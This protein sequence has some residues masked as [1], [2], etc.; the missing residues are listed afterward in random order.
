MGVKWHEHSLKY[1]EMRVRYRLISTTLD[2]CDPRF[3]H[4]DHVTTLLAHHLV[5]DGINLLNELVGSH[6]RYTEEVE[7][8]RRLHVNHLNRFCL[9]AWPLKR[10]I[11]PFVDRLSWNL[12]QQFVSLGH[13]S[14][15]RAVKC[16]SHSR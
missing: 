15:H 4:T 13:C 5:N 16:A 1:A 12:R 9:F 8:E 14:T 7:N 10:E 6:I 11:S 3:K 2:R